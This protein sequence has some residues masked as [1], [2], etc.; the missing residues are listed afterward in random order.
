MR[1]EREVSLVSN[2]LGLNKALLSNSQS[3]CI[4][5]GRQHNIT[6]DIIA[7]VHH[8]AAEPALYTTFVPQMSPLG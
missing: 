5:F 4:E 3:V 8:R 7:Y 2:S 1:W 6:S